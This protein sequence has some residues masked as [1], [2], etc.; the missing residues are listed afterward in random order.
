MKCQVIVSEGETEPPRQTDHAVCQRQTCRVNSGRLFSSV[1]VE[2]FPQL[3][4]SSCSVDLVLFCAGV[5]R[6]PG[7]GKKK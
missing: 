1:T 6:Q 3:C 5:K 2:Y 4:C 7:G